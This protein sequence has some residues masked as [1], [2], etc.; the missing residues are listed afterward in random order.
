[1]E[2]GS[3]RASTTRV[4]VS[5]D[6]RERICG[7]VAWV[8]AIAAKSTLGGCPVRRVLVSIWEKASA[9]TLSIPHTWRMVEVNW[10]CSQGGE[11]V[12]PSVDQIKSSEC[13]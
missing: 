13:R 9:T 3:G 7:S 4:E 10:E 8:S 6:W 2:F 12:W 11:L 5:E 1:M